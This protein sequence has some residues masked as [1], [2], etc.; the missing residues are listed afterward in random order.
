M[1]DRYTEDE[2]VH[3][4]QTVTVFDQPELKVNEH[5]W[6]QQGYFITDCCNPKKP[7]CHSGGIPIP[8]GKVL[9]KTERGYDLRNE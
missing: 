6:V 7:T 4:P 9:I 3:L 8:S 5:D 2:L 1:S